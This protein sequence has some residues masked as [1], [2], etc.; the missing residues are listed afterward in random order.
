MNDF[1][2]SNMVVDGGNSFVID[3]KLIETE[4]MD[5]ELC[6]Q[7]LKECD[8]IGLSYAVVKDISNHNYST[9]KAF[10]NNRMRA[11]WKTIIVDKV[12]YENI[13]S[14]YAIHIFCTK[15]QEKL[16]PTFNKL[17]ATR[18]SDYRTHVEPTQKSKGIKKLVD[19][20]GGSYKD[21][22]VF[23]DG[24]NDLDM[25]CQPWLKIAM[26]NAVEEIKELAD[27]ITDD[28]NKDGIYNACEKY[29]WFKD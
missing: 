3:G 21:V 23:G 8:Q 11:F 13:D 24:T 5:T 7:L 27:Y 10:A 17:T 20:L 6:R 28:C 12:D 2:L 26:G 9:D 19:Y 1:G 16:L 29:N 22:V 14:F 4:P 18:I 25:F 15:E